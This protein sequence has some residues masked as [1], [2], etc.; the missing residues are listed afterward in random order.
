M[1]SI[2]DSAV[3]NER[4]FFPR[5][6]AT[7]CPPSS[8]DRWIAV[9]ANATL[10]AR[11]HPCR[12]ARGAVLLFHGNAEVVADYDAMRERFHER[13]LSLAVVDF[14][15]YGRSTA[16][17]TLRTAIDDAPL[18]LRALRDELTLN[19]ALPLVVFGRSLGGHCAAAIA[20]ATP[21]LCDAIVLE[22]AASD[23]HA[24]IARRGL[25]LDA[26]LT[27]DER[28]VFDPRPKLARCTVPALV[29]HGAMDTLISP[30]EAQANF[31]ALGS[32]DKR[33]VLVEGRGHNDLSLARS[34][35]DAIERLV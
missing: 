14:R 13:G 27:D 16:T 5:R 34:Y 24:L 4:L 22:S 11:I 29:L 25:R 28:A 9:D 3:F 23:L 17:P 21:A 35:W 26:P 31:D 33:L 20:G 19:D 12:A 8:V 32:Q 7:P 1:R 30:R 15:G 6:D 18:V 2:F 10:H